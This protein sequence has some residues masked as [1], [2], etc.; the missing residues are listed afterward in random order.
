VREI[1]QGD[2]PQ[3]RVIHTANQGLAAARN[4]GAEV[5]QGEFLA[6]F[7]ADDIVESEFFARAIDV[8]QRYTNVSFV[9]SWVRFFEGSLGI[10]PT[11]NTEF[12]YLLGHNMLACLVVL[13][14]A[15]F[16][17]QARNK[18]EIEY[19]LEDFEGWVRFVTAGGVGV[20]LCHPFVRYRVRSGSMFRRA[21]RDQLLYMHDLISQYHAEAYREWGEELFNLQNANGPAYLWNH[22]AREAE[23]PPTSYVTTLLAERQRLA[24][25]VQTL[26][27]AW[28]EHVR[29][30]ASQR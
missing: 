8:L 22:P 19:S 6:F 23:E 28:D 24:A 7:D 10:W 26:G 1:E 14:R 3:V 13:R 21:N 17:A 11:W 18:P 9:Y 2:H 12:P 29:F 15:A 4:V 30:I 16:L 20:S 5:A 25:E 27:K